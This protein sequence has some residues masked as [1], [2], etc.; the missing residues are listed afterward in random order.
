MIVALN[1]G[2][3]EDR[4]ES[5]AVRQCGRGTAAQVRHAAGE[6]DSISDGFPQDSVSAPLRIHARTGSSGLFAP[7]CPFAFLLS[8]DQSEGWLV[9]AVGIEPIAQIQALTITLFSSAIFDSRLKAAADHS[10]TLVQARSSKRT[11]LE[12]S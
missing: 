2:R 10:M 8:P 11:Y 12:D 9:G 1:R 6:S 4:R 7:F 3:G 5:G